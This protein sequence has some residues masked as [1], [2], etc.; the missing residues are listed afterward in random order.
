MKTRQVL[1]YKD[2]EGEWRWQLVAA[3]G[4]DILADSGQSY[5]ERNKARRIA[6]SVFKG[7]GYLLDREEVL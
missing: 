3:N 1:S 4:Y 2:A 5:Q 7:T 6:R